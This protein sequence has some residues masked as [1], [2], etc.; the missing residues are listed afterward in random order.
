MNKHKRVEKMGQETT[1]RA[2]EGIALF[3]A[4]GKYCAHSKVD[5]LDFTRFSKENVGSLDITMDDTVLMKILETTECFSTDQRNLLFL[6]LNVPD[7]RNIRD[8]TTATVVLSN[9]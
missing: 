5:K 1:Y 6:E 9:L 8:S 7:L 2:D 4:C 3:F